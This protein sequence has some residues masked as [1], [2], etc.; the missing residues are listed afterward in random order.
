MWGGGPS[1]HV[2]VMNS[3]PR[4][5]AVAGLRDALRPRCMPTGPLVGLHTLDVDAL[6]NDPRGLDNV[7]EARLAA[8]SVVEEG[9]VASWLLSAMPGSVY[10][11]RNRFKLFD[12][13]N[14]DLFAAGPGGA[15]LRQLPV[16]ANNLDPVFIREHARFIHVKTRTD[17][18]LMR[19]LLYASS[20]KERAS[21]SLRTFLRFSPLGGIDYLC[22]DPEDGRAT[23]D[24]MASLVALRIRSRV[25]AARRLADHLAAEG[26][27]VLPGGRREIGLDFG[28]VADRQ[29]EVW[30][31]AA[32]WRIWADACWRVLGDR[33][34]AWQLTLELHYSGMP[35][36]EAVETAHAVTD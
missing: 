19:T 33:V 30:A 10:S 18:K 8:L 22:P 26:K 20:T 11:M 14:S 12:V 15:K 28:S 35:M 27:V 34:S 5:S 21:A 1:P 7:T 23:A 13:S 24:Q 31:R 6:R 4:D 32:C 36:Y 25:H 29:A 17:A 2:D 16:L 9:E 3:D